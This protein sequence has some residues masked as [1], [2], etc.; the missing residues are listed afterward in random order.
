MRQPARLNL[1]HSRWP[2]RRFRAD[3]VVAVPIRDADGRRGT[4]EIGRLAS[5]ADVRPRSPH[6][7]WSSSARFS[8]AGSKMRAKDTA[9]EKSERLER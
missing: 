8:G 5:H 2:N 4:T 1:K 3:R 6:T 7:P 9:S